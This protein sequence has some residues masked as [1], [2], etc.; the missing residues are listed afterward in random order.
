MTGLWYDAIYLSK[1][2][3]V[4]PTDIKLLTSARLRE[5]NTNES[6]IAEFEMK[7]P[8]SLK[9]GNYFLIMVADSLNVLDDSNKDNNQNYTS[10]SIEEQPPVDLSLHD[11]NMFSSAF[12]TFNWTLKSNRPVSKSERC[13][14]YY[15]SLDN[16]YDEDDYEISTSNCESFSIVQI[17]PNTLSEI[18]TSKTVEIPLIADGDYHG[19]VRSISS[20]P[21]TNYDNNQV[22]SNETVTVEVQT[23]Q[24]DTEFIA[25]IAENSDFLFKFFVDATINSFSIE[26]TTKSQNAFHDL[27]VRN[28]KMPT[29][30]IY[31]ARSLNYFSFNQTLRVRNANPG[32]YY[33][34]LKSFMGSNQKSNYD[35]ALIVKEIKKVQI[36]SIYPLKLNLKGSNTVKITGNFEPKNLQVTNLFSVNFSDLIY[37]FRIFKIS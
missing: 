9:S 7:I 5:L 29:Q 13:D 22:A 25:T 33:L 14:N 24:F 36:D 34:L 16:L 3:T 18:R 31:K 15:M 26:L 1:F 27:Y 21:E 30:N 19:I 8:I 17:N 10:L 32:V 35:I 28:D 23:L 12:L 20:V 6:Y 37:I 4:Q 2:S 11:L